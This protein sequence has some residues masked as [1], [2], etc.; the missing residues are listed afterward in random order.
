MNTS[1][2]VDFTRVFD[3]V[4][5]QQQKYPQ[6]ACVNSFVNGRWQAWSTGEVQK[7]TDEISC[8]LLERG[9]QPGDT[10]AVVPTMGSPE[11]IVTDLACQQIG[12]I[13]IPIH[14]TSSP[15]EMLFILDETQ[16]RLCITANAGLY[17]K[18]QLVCEKAAAAPACYHL[19]KREQGYFPAFNHKAVAA[20][21]VQLEKRKASV[22]ENDIL[23]ILYTSG[24]S[25]TP[26]GAMLSHKNVVSNIKAILPV[27]PVEPG[28]R[29]LSFLPF[30]HIFERTAC[31]AYLAFGVNIYF[32]HSKESIT[33]DFKS[34]KP[35]FCTTVPKTLEKMYD[36]LL[37][38][39]ATKNVLKRKLIGWAMG[40]GQGFKGGRQSGLLFRLN[41][42]LA[43]MLV[44]NHWRNALGGK[45]RFV[46]VGAAALR[47]DIAR[48]FS[49]TGVLVLSGY[50]MTEAS[51]FIS[52][53]RPQPGMYRFGTVG[54]PLPGI[55]VKIDRADEESEGEILVNGPNVMRGYFKRPELT[56][57]VLT[58]GWLRTGDIGKF[59]D[60]KFLMITGRKKDIFKTTAGIYIS[61]QPLEDHFTSSPFIS[62]CLVI[63]YNKPF[64]SAL[65]VPNFTWLKHWCE[66]SGVHWT[67]PTFM[68]HNI[69]VVQIMQREIDRLNSN[70]ESYKRIRKFILSD[71]EWT[72]DS[73]DLTASFKV[74]RSVLL[75]KHEAAI[76]K[77]YS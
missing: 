74:K 40:V 52:V 76:N 53:N 64:V 10:I 28:D 51:P 15:E 13:I 44:L 55:A 39:Q 41:L 18:V 72:I 48:L 70:L 47:P 56:R 71:A 50:G 58:D 66:E 45:A 38:Q 43:R 29:A 59:A 4:A 54:L 68:I 21:K 49:A 63:G 36:Y 3:L 24:T 17:Y 33:A 34:V 42:F 30:S 25:G 65:L 35:A 75:A 12:L 69:K 32:S 31:F 62:H 46:I 2:K 1:S 22:S 77:L 11:W 20:T 37:E 14:P 7:K 16:A 5:Y 9:C 23:A 57:E 8:W 73:G 19:E 60:H 67:S 27:L 61:P 6:R 26:K